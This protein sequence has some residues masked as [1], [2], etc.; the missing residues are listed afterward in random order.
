MINAWANNKNKPKRKNQKKKK[1][2]D[3]DIVRSM[4]ALMTRHNCALKSHHA[5]MPPNHRIPSNTFKKECNEDA[6]T[7]R[8]DSRI[9]PGFRRGVGK[10]YNQHPSRRKDDARKCHCVGASQTDKDFS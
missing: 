2:T 3:V 8:T 10:G 7:T 9:S 5:P 4:K 6:A 1:E